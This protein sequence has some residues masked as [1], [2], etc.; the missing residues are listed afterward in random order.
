MK[1]LF[2]ILALSM[3]IG[4]FSSCVIVTHEEPTYTLYFCNDTKVQH[5]YD[6]YLKN[7]NNTE[8]AISDSYCEV[9][10]RTSAGLSGLS[11]DYYQIWYCVYSTR[12]DDFYVHSADYVYLDSDVTFYLSDLT[13]VRGSP[14]RSATLENAEAE[15]LVFV[16]SKG[17]IY[18]AE[19]EVIS[20]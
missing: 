17:N 7:K 5:V 1:K 19:I 12:T 4:L 15:K 14:K 13:C 11:K 2:S 18:P 16:D 10:T 8:F 9:P 6:W 3:V 20:K